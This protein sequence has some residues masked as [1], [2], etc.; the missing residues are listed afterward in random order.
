MSTTS[1]LIPR[2]DEELHD[3]AALIAPLELVERKFHITSK[4]QALAG[5]IDDPLARC[6]EAVEDALERLDAGLIP[7]PEPEPLLPIGNSADAPEPRTLRVY[8]L[9]ELAAMEPEHVDW[10]W[11][12]Y[13]GAGDA[14]SYTHLRA[15][16]TRH[17]LVCRL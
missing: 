15:H 10:V 7:L 12:P 8:S 9:P 13:V 2:N 1:T 14:V 17:D 4:A 11:S 16:E 6:H 3:W 5:I